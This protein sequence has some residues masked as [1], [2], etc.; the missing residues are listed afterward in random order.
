ML[1][2]VF[3]RRAAATVRATSSVGPGERHRHLAGARG[4]DGR[5]DPGLGGDRYGDSST[6]FPQG[7]RCMSVSSVP[8]RLSVRRF[9]ETARSDA[10]WVQP[11]VVAFGLSAFIVYSTWA[12]FQ[13]A[14]YTYGPYL[15]PFY[16]PVIFGD[17]PFAWFGP[18]P[19]WWPG[20]LPF[21]PALLIL[22]FPG[23]FRV[24]CYYYR[25]A[26]YKA[27]WAD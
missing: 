3:D 22:P 18:K 10:W 27:M 26:Y 19:G 24:T 2:A 15:S 9:G 1:G 20:L 25:G 8:V 5:T 23:L 16:S 17:A 21:S 12:A 11:I 13:N 4:G 14:H 6:R 7:I